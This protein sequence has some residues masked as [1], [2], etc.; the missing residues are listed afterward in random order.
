MTLKMQNEDFELLISEGSNALAFRKYH[1]QYDSNTYHSEALF[2]KF[3]DSKNQ[4]RFLKLIWAMGV[5]WPC[6]RIELAKI[7]PDVCPV[8][9]TPLDYGRG[10]NRVFNPLVNNDDGYYQPTV[11]HRVSRAEAAKLGWT[12]EQINCI[13]NYVVV[14]RKANTWK[15][16]C[17]SEH[18]FDRFVA[19]MKRVYF[20]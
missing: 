14:C 1:H 19:G 16:D 17:P 3:K 10:Y 20:S 15:N 2:E 4:S 11:D 13:D 9:G 7:C 8:M 5:D 6:D 18:V 12:E